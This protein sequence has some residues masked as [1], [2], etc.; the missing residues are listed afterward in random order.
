M[1]LCISL[2]IIKLKA[3]HT[4]YVYIQWNLSIEDTLNK[5]HLSN[6]DTACNPNHIDLCTN[7]L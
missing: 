1:W 4:R 3:E 5:G 2:S 6:E 7:L